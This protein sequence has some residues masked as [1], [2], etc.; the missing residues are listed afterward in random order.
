MTEPIDFIGPIASVDAKK[1]FASHAQAKSCCVAL[2]QVFLRGSV[3][4]TVVVVRGLSGQGYARFCERSIK[5]WSP[6]HYIA[7]ADS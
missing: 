5:K 2:S 7:N 1:F 6:S 4:R 3:I